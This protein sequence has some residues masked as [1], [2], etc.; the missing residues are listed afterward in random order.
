MIKLND[1]FIQVH[2]NYSKH[3]PEKSNNRI[4]DIP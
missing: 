2:T 4:Q 3:V 1:V